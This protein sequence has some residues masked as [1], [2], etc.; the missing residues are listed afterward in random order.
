M[1]NDSPNSILGRAWRGALVLCGIAVLL[2][3]AVTLISRI[4]V[5][6]VV[7]ATAIALIAIIITA[8][9]YWRRRSQW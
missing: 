7:V 8:L 9:V 3:V 5:E 4:W 1:S 2:N 6:L